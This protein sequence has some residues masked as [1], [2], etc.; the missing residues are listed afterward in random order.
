M[1][2]KQFRIIQVRKRD[3]SLV[4]FDQNRITNAILRAMESVG[5]DDVKRAKELSDK[6]VVILEYKY[7]DDNI[8]GVENIQDVVEK[9]LIK[10]GEAE[11]AKAYILYRQKHKEVREAKKTL[12]SVT[13]TISEYLDKVDWRVR[14]NSNEDYSFSGLLLYTAGKV[15]ANY[16]LSEIYTKDISEAHNKGYIHI[17]DLSHGF[18]GYCAGWSLKN[19][20]LSGFGG[21]PNKADAGPA[22]HM[23]VVVHQM[24]NFIGCLQMEFAG[25]QAF[26]ST[27]TLMAPFV[28]IDNLSY[29]QVKQNMQKLVFSLN[30][31]SRFG[32][33]YPFSNLTFDWTVPKDMRYQKAIVGGKEQN[34]TYGDCQKEMDMINKAFLE[35]MHEG[36]YKGSVFTFPIPTY[37]LTKDFDWNS[38]NAELLFKLTAKYGLPYFQNYIGSNLDPSSVRAMCCRLNLNMLELINRPGSMWGIGDNSVVGDTPVW[39]KRNNIWEMRP[40][41]EVYGKKMKNIKTIS[42]DPLTSKIKEAD[43]SCCVKHGKRDVF[44]LRTNQGNISITQDHCMFNITDGG[45][46]ANATIEDIKRL[47][48][49]IAPKLP[50]I[51]SMYKLNIVEKL[52]QNKYDDKR[53]RIIFDDPKVFDKLID[54][55]ISKNYIKKFYKSTFTNIKSK[56]KNSNFGKPTIPFN[57]FKILY[58]AGKIN[59]LKGILLCKNKYKMPLLL[60]LCYEFGFIVGLFLAEGSCHEAC[61]VANNNIKILEL[62]REYTK[63]IFNVTPVLY[64]PKKNKVGC[65][66]FNSD[67][68]KNYLRF[69]LNLEGNFATKAIPQYISNSNEDMIKGVIDGFYMGDGHKTKDYI[70]LTTCNKKL[71]NGF[72]VLLKRIRS[73]FVLKYYKKKKSFTIRI[74]KYNGRIVS[75][76]RKF[77]RDIRHLIHLFSKGVAILKKQIS[78]KKALEMGLPQAFYNIQYVPTEN[79]VLKGFNILKKRNLMNGYFN[80]VLRFMKNYERVDVLDISYIGKKDVYDLSVPGYENFVAGAGMFFTHNTGSLGVV[81]IN[82][83]RIAYESRDKE[84]FFEKVGYYMEIAKNSLEI[85]RKIV[86][87]NLKNGLMPYTKRYLGTFN[88]HFSTIGLCGMNEACLNLLNED[89][90]TKEGKKFAIE[91]LEFMKE[92]IKKFQQETGNLYNLEATPAEG[93]SYRLARLDKKMY[94][95]IIT[96]GD[97]VPFLTNSTQ[98]PV[99]YTNDLILALEHQNDIQPLYTGGTIFYTFLGERIETEACKIFIKKNVYKIQLPYFNITPTFSVCDD[100]GYLQG[101]QYTCPECGKETNVYSRVVGYIRPV[102][103]WNDGKQEEWKKRKTF[104]TDLAL[105]KEFN[106]IKKE[107]LVSYTK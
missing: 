19:L 84:E 76:K 92:K 16:A 7:G 98:L 59:S 102:R 67:F 105:K 66:T 62:C 58:K 3:G 48:Y 43:V 91:T 18:I 77:G 21:V 17:H 83:N 25:A 4:L 40:I 68:V 74:T 38:E 10:S 106:I 90:V 5:V 87:N 8:P 42:F 94:P 34:F 104:N 61:L 14:E 1:N 51:G 37:N 36:D 85:K 39:I 41:S 45:D 78:T 107:K 24:I 2:E 63:K 89:I 55:K 13:D 56:W 23:D 33:Q 101:E 99:D 15:I 88:N 12:L 69:G 47:G 20:L 70:E 22:K 60:D 100:H 11:I 6:V 28:K 97:K 26:S 72:M 93:A 53:A 79:N 71:A 46:I 65:V 57:L 49:F 54:Y 80:T 96:S 82:V 9:V 44:R 29:K 73:S 64:N 103:R 81:T 32:S 75:I 52:I 50:K 30:I 95:K 86:G 31:P 27:N 35:V